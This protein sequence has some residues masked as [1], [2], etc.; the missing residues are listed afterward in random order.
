M[1]RRETDK[2]RKSNSTFY[3][4]STRPVRSLD[5]ILQRVEDASGTLMRR[6]VSLGVAKHDSGAWRWSTR[7]FAKT[8]EIADEGGC[9]RKR[10]GERRETGLHE[11]HP[12][13]RSSIDVDAEVP[14]PERR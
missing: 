5:D 10:A 12:H 8:S 13:G 14:E 4:R 7:S 11:A 3:S 6:G 2:I 9:E 1:K